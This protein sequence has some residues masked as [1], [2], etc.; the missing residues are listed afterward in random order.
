MG[1]LAISGIHYRT[2]V[3]LFDP[4]YFVGFG[5]LNLNYILTAEAQRR[6]DR[7]TDKLKSNYL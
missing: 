7:Y 4:A 3:A 1:N 2:G 5:L 6:N